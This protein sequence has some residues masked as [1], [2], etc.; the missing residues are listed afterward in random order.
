MVKAGKKLP[1]LNFE[2]KTNHKKNEE[3]PSEDNIYG[4]HTIN[5]C[6]ST[7]LSTLLLFCFTGF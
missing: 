7:L 5:S 3:K 2:N 4:N 1:H 6:S